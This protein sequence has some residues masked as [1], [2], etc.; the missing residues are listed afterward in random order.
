MKRIFQK[1][2]EIGSY[3][4]VKQYLDLEGI[5]PRSAKSWSTTAIKKILNNPIYHGEC[6]Y[7]DLQWMDE[8]IVLDISKFIQHFL[9]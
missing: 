2:E 7:K 1:Y 5:P 4:G 8:D 6:H 3:H 9:S